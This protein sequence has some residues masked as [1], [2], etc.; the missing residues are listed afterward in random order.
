MQGQRL[1][2]V[3]LI[4]LGVGLGLSAFGPNATLA[5]PGGTATGGP[6]YTVIETEG[7][8]LL[9]TDNSTNTLYYYTV[10]P[11]KTVGDELKLRGS[12][13][14]S[15]VGKPGIRPTKAGPPAPPKP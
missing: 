4:V 5:Q 14:L 8:N 10:D 13:D 2:A 1:W 12:L 11:D 7:T 9:V 6:K 3:A 15:Q